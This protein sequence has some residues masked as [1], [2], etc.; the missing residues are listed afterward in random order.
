MKNTVVARNY[1]EALLGVAAKEKAVEQY[2]DLMDAIAGA[3]ATTPDVKA[4][5]MSP[6]VRKDVKQQVLAKALKKLAPES[7]VRFLQAVVQRGRQG[8]LSEISEAYQALSDLHFHRVHASVTTAHE[9]DKKLAAQI[10]KKLE[11]AVGMTVLAH[12]HTDKAV[13]G[14]VVVRVGDR[15]FDGSIRRRLMALKRAMLTSGAR[16]A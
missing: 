9:P 8:L 2:G 3:V 1:A 12:F 16:P 5:L 6:K 14:G 10:T 13:M 4:V 11:E 7:F 15:V